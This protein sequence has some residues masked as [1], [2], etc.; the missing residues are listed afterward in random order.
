MSFSFHIQERCVRTSVLVVGI[1]KITDESVRL[2]ALPSTDTATKL[3]AHAVQLGSMRC[4]SVLAC[5]LTLCTCLE[6]SCYSGC[7]KPLDLQVA[8]ASLAGFSLFMT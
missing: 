4:C 2:E 1:R 8:T 5:A 3:Y 6:L 7:P